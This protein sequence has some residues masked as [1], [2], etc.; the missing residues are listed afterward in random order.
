MDSVIAEQVSDKTLPLD[1]FQ[2]AFLAYEATH[3]PMSFGIGGILLMEGTPPAVDE[4]RELF[5]RQLH[6]LPQLG[7]RLSDGPLS[8]AVWEPQRDIDLRTLIGERLTGPGG[9]RGTVDELIRR[10]FDHSQP[11]WRVWL[12]HGYAADEFALIYLGHHALHDGMSVATTIMSTFADGASVKESKPRI[13]RPRA[14]AGAKSSLLKTVAHSISACRPLA[15]PLPGS[16]DF[17]ERTIHWGHT[18]LDQLREIGH[19]H[20]TTANNVYLAAMTHVLREWPASPWHMLRDKGKPVWAIVP[21]SIGSEQGKLSQRSVGFRVPLPCDDPDPL[22][23]LAA[24]DA[25]LSPD[26]LGTQRSTAQSMIKGMPYRL[27][28]PWVYHHFS[29]RFAHLI[30]TN[31]P[32]CTHEATVL[33]RRIAATVPIGFLPARH[34]LGAAMTSYRDLAVVSF[35]TDSRL[36]GAEA[37]PDMW[38]DAVAELK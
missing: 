25:R 29:D 5:R 31:V 17:G 37:L 4:V 16:T 33:G 14:D 15:R 23:R 27:F 34:R 12:V 35:L 13:P 22:S 21:L 3:P 24:L 10:P 36:P 19:Q 28:L 38:L 30:A 1:P 20:N 18:S 7:C 9:L 2:R 6:L 11:L 32:G 8:R 26:T